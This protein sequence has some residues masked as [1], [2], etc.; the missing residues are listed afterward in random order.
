MTLY[1]LTAEQWPCSQADYKMTDLH[2]IVRN[3]IKTMTIVLS[4]RELR[5]IN[6]ADM[7]TLHITG[8]LTLKEFPTNWIF[9]PIN[10]GISA[11]LTFNPPPS[12]FSS[13]CYQ[14]D[15]YL[16][17]P[18]DRLKRRVSTH[19]SSHILTRPSTD[20]AGLS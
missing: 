20:R 12:I 15:F 2:W 7:S 8:A 4:A 6:N 16:L 11:G 3:G 13:L 19:R 1:C 10:S 14:V 5:R 17:R 9:L 18:V